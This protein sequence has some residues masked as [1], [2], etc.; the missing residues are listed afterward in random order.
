MTNIEKFCL[1]WNDF[2][3]NI[4]TT[5]ESMRGDP[6]FAD[7]TLACEDGEQIMAHKVILAASSPF[8]QNLLRK[9]QHTHP[10]IYMRGLKSNNLKAIVDFLYYGEANIYQE[11]LDDFLAFAEELQLKGLSNKEHNPTEYYITPESIS[12]DKDHPKKRAS[13]EMVDEKKF[14]H[15]N[16]VSDFQEQNEIGER[17]VA[18]SNPVY[19]GELKQLDSQIKSMMSTGSQIMA[20]GIKA[21]SACQVCGKEGRYHV[22]KDHIE[23][24]HID[25]VLHSCNLCDKTFRSRHSLK[26]HT[27]RN[28]K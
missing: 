20:N 14:K 13:M 26:M 22:I 27:I 18:I 16:V 12:V 9:N 25:G 2:Q 23:L 1:K 17:S 15:E 19:S 3:T 24:H 6:D 21:E 11:N 4:S 5:F 8:F 10:L 7:V 28:H